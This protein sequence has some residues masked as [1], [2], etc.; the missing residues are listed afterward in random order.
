MHFLGNG[1][2]GN[3]SSSKTS[4]S[5]GDSVSMLNEKVPATPLAEARLSADELLSAVELL[6]SEKLVSQVG[7][8]FQFHIALRDGTHKTYF[9]DLS[10]GAGRA[11]HGMPH[12]NPDVV[13]QMT[14]EDLL[15]M[16][17]GTLR[18]FGAYTNGQLKLR[19]DLKTAMKLEEVIKV[20]RQQ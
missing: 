16:F 1:S 12:Q 11:G 3:G 15:A 5:K 13:F 7:A 9:V 8:C 17:E 19:G 2:G 18:P 10:K 4:H 14:E 20:T 6:L